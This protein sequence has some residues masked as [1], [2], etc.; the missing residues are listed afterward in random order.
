MTLEESYEQAQ[1]ITKSRAKNFYFGIRLLPKVKRD[2][3]CAVY[4]FF[5]ESDDISDDEKR[6]NRRQQLYEWKSLVRKSKSERTNTN[7]ILPAFY[8]TLTKYSIPPTYFEELLDGTLSDLT[9]SR[10]QNFD[11][12]YSYCYRVA[13]TVGLV[14]LHIF[15]F[16]GSDIALK[17]A[18]E[19]GIAFQLTNILRDVK[20]DGERGRIYLPLSDFSSFGITEADFL[21]GAES[22]SMKEFLKFQIERAYRY[23]DSSAPLASRVDPE[24]RPSLQAMTQIYR[25]LLGKVDT[26]GTDIFKQRASLS[27]LEKIALAGKTAVAS[28]KRA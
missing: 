7:P 26:L 23:Y 16:D 20:E 21:T 18:E 5:R 15:G 3:L 28:L 27:K 24:S 25:T 6:V 1:N 17:Q 11:E 4:A 8:D 22:E 10:Y 13:S 14:C 2:S 19:R 12:L 9:V